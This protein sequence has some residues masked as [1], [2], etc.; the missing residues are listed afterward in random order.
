MKY[1]YIVCLIL[2]SYLA[3][4]L[5]A[6][7]L[8]IQLSQ[9]K[10]TFVL[11]H[12]RRDEGTVKAAIRHGGSGYHY[13]CLSSEGLVLEEGSFDFPAAPLLQIPLEPLRQTILLQIPWRDDFDTF[14]CFSTQS[15]D[16]D[17]D[18]R[19]PR[20][21]LISF[22]ISEALVNSRQNIRLETAYDWQPDSQPQPVKLIDNG[23]DE[24]RLVLVF[25]GDG[26][27]ESEQEQYKQDVENSINQIL[28]FEPWADYADLINVYYIENTISSQSRI[29]I[30]SPRDTIF[31][32]YYYYGLSYRLIW[33]P[34][35][36]QL[37]TDYLSQYAPASFD[38]AFVI[39][40][41]DSGA[42]GSGGLYSVFNLHTYS[43]EIAVHEFGHSFAY[44]ADE[45]VQESIADRYTYSESLP[46][47]MQHLSR[48]LSV[49]SNDDIPWGVW[50]EPGVVFPGGGSNGIGLFEGAFYHSRGYYRPQSNCLMRGYGVGFCEVCAEAHVVRLY[51]FVS[52]IDSVS[53]VRSSLIITEQTPIEFSVDLSQDF[54]PNIQVQWFMD[55]QLIGEGT[56]ITIDPLVYSS[57]TVDLRVEVTDISDWIRHDPFIDG[58]YNPNTGRGI[59]N[60]SENKVKDSFDWRIQFNTFDGRAAKI[61]YVDDDATG[62]NDGT[63]WENAYIYLQDA[64]ADAYLAEKPV[65]I[66]VAHGTYTPDKGAGQTPGDREAT[67]Q[68]IN[69]VTITGGYAG[70]DASDPNA[71]DIKLYE[72][73]LSGDLLGNDDAP[74]DPEDPEK[75]IYHPRCSE[76]VYH[77]VTASGT[78]NS[79]E[80]DGCILTRGNDDRTEYIF[81]G[82]SIITTYIGHGAGLYNHEGCPIVSNCSFLDNRASAGGSGM[83]NKNGNPILTNCT[84]SGNLGGGV[85]NS[86]GSGPILT[87]C[88]FI[89]NSSNNGGGMYNDNNSSPTLTNCTFNG[90]S[91]NEGGGMYNSN[92]SPTLINCTFSGNSANDGGGMYNWNNSNSTMT[93][94]TFSGNIALTMFG[95]NRDGISTQIGGDGGGIYISNS[96]L[97]LINCTFVGNIAHDGGGISNFLS[98]TIFTNCIFWGDHPNEIPLYASSGFMQITYSNIQ[99]GWE[100]AGNIDEDPLFAA[101]GY[102]ADVND[103]NIVIEPNDPNAVWI[104]GDYHLKSQAGRFEPNS[105]SWVVDDVTSPCIDAGDPNSPVG[106]EPEPNGGRINMGAYGG[107]S[108][109]GKSQ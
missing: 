98:N 51:D 7:V 8:L 60:A 84:F 48:D 59:H 73:V 55:E 17:A 89:G 85:T 27:T 39:A 67:F 92:S 80:I 23:P 75:Y 102:W 107:T 24:N 29:G 65:E 71:R 35:S 37:I 34:E 101:P 26:Y 95:S 33:S 106:D 94:C 19:S 69:G 15:L 63:S 28:L 2:L 62:A 68:L 105:G 12:I 72:T 31:R 83:Y 46:N 6:D 91:A 76:N 90:N 93:N 9:D 10:D 25:V 81:I 42:G 54:N 14:E 49:I 44:L 30:D 86:N 41:D 104:D 109:A 61:I 3:E 79:A 5:F 16:A 70:I 56:Q 52:P 78:D 108:E 58:S 18:N 53:P 64:L 88:I 38:F 1:L 66:R 87:N 32:L 36:T 13:R 43:I 97:T 22:S 47:V 74:F 20:R 103:T 100:G 96:N 99:G 82:T 11:E 21:K 40:N 45:Y 57:M 50:V 77:V 4:P